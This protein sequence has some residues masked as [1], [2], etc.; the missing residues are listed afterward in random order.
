M[1]PYLAA[2]FSVSGAHGVLVLV[3][4]VVFLISA[5]LAL[6][7]PPQLNRAVAGTALGLA[8]Y[9]LALLWT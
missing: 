6:L 7:A 2:S 1:S 4:L 5:V 3:A 8:V 9:M